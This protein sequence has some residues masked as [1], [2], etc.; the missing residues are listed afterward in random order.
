MILSRLGVAAITLLV[1][2]P[3][4]LP[5]H[6]SPIP[7]FNAEWTAA[8]L[9]LVASLTLIGAPRLPVPGAAMLALALAATVVVQAALGLAPVPQL[10]VLFGLYLLWAALLACTGR[11]LAESWGQARLARVLATALLAGSVLAALASLFQPWLAGLGWTG[12]SPRAGGPVGQLNHLSSYLWLGLTSA[13]YLRSTDAL[14]KPLFWST[15]ILLT[16]TAVLVGQRSS[17]IYALALTCIAVWQGR[18]VLVGRL[19]ESRRRALGVGLLFLLLQPLPHVLPSVYESGTQPAP[20]LRAVQQIAGPSIRL[21][22]MR[23]SVEGIK[24]A[25]WLGSGIGSFP[26]MALAYSEKIPPEDNPGSAEHAHNLLLDIGAELG[27][28]AALLAL[29]GAGLWLWRL[30]QRATPADAAWACGVVAILGLHSMIEYPLWHSYFLGLLAL[31]AG[32]FGV[33]RPIGRRLTSVV[34]VVAVVAWGGLSLMELRRDY[35][36]LES[37]LALGKQPAT[38][39]PA[40][41]ALLRIPQTSLLSP[42]VSTTACVSLDPLEVP[43]NDG[44]AVCRVAMGFAPTIESGV[45]MVVLLWRS[46]DT[47]GARK[48]LRGL[49]QVSRDNPGGI[50]ALL[51]LLTARN[52]QLGEL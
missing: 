32:A 5:E 27:L 34:L 37:A 44:L 15:A 30:P 40:Q 26:G 28:P 42:W 9:G 45:N 49:R 10:A 25:P 4:L 20:A 50:D 52:T 19:A 2:L 21:Q 7:S 11:H 14:S 12:F 29:L 47:L 17:F 31:V 43:L 33:S 51:T 23:V 35:W 41:A 3:F 18:G 46:G 6:T 48:L 36:L 22:L 24:S 39:A 13:L 1:S 8:V 38:L 16:L